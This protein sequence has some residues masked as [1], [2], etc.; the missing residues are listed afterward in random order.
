[1]L[2]HCNYIHVQD[3]HQWLEMI[4]CGCPVRMLE[5]TVVRHSSQI[6]VQDLQRWLGKILRGQPVLMTELVVLDTI[7]LLSGFKAKQ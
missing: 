5:L 7:C 4:G 6:H 2:R 1:M 3:A